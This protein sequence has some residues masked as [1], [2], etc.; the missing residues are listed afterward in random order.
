MNKQE[1]TGGSWESIIKSG[2]PNH[3]CP[4]L[5]SALHHCACPWSSVMNIFMTF[6]PEKVLNTL[7]SSKGG[8]SSKVSRRKGASLGD[9]VSSQLLSLSFFLKPH[10]HTHSDENRKFGADF[11]KSV[12]HSFDQ[13]V[14]IGKFSRLWEERI[15][16]R[17]PLAPTTSTLNTRRTFTSLPLHKTHLNNPYRDMPLR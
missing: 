13:H 10:T 5:K 17:H 15:G 3:I 6:I 7:A 8:I 1:K 16:K 12:Y 4:T 11:I 2:R 14:A 9:H